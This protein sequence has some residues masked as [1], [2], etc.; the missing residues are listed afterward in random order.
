LVSVSI[1]L[2]QM[3][4]LATVQTKW[5]MNPAAVKIADQGCPLTNC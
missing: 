1:F 2:S 3:A 4:D 5:K